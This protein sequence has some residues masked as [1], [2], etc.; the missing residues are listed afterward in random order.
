MVRQGDN[1]EQ[2][3]NHRSSTLTITYHIMTTRF[4]PLPLLSRTR[5]SPPTPP[6][7]LQETRLRKLSNVGENQGEQSVFATPPPSPSSPMSVCSSREHLLSDIDVE[8]IPVIATQEGSRWNGFLQEFS[9]GRAAGREVRDYLSFTAIAPCYLPPGIRTPAWILE[10]KRG[11]VPSDLLKLGPGSAISLQDISLW[12]ALYVP[13]VPTLFGII[14]CMQRREDGYQ[15]ATVS[16][17]VYVPN[18]YDVIDTHFCFV[19]IPIQFV[20]PTFL[21]AR[22][23]PYNTLGQTSF[24]FAEAYPP[25]RVWEESGMGLRG[26][27]MGSIHVE[28]RHEAVRE[29]VDEQNMLGWF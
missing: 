12:E 8:T 20:D 1:I 7:P 13:A 15:V 27:G 19:V 18:L 3:K 6:H 14:D 4:Q 28:E 5:A 22:I 16:T 2:I 17:H 25:W 23:S 21:I 10:Q 26:L 24:G 11:G 9:Q 29:W